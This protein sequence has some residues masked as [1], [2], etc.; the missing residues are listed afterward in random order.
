MAQITSLRI[1]TPIKPAS[2]LR[3][4]LYVSLSSAIILLAWL[5]DLSL[6]PYVLLLTICVLVVSYLAL[7]RPILLHL[8]QPPLSQRA[9][10]G[11]QLLMRSSRGDALWQAD[12]RAVQRHHWIISFEFVIVEPYQRSLSVTVFRDQV[13]L[14]EWR[15]LTV[16]ANIMLV[17]SA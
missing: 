12:L 3:T 15:E 1:D 8:T 9:N 13:S 14:D 11:W 17:T 16:L 2:P 10:Q 5:A 7:S 4:L 6:L